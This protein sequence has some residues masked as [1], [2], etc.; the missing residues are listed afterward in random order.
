MKTP[1]IYLQV[2]ALA[3]VILLIA[4][5]SA[6]E[7]KINPKCSSESFHGHPDVWIKSISWSHP[8]FSLFR[9][10]ASSILITSC[11]LST[12]NYLPFCGNMTLYYL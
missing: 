9:N 11:N 3:T 2:I 1:K 8:L 6:A 7:V 10:A 5:P 12:T 4:E